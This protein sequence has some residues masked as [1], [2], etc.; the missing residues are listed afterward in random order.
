MP[1]IHF[2]DKYRNRFF[3][4]TTPGPVQPHMDSECLLW[5]AGKGKNGYGQ[6]FAGSTVYAHRYAY[7]LAHGQ[8]DPQ[9]LILHKC[10]VKLCVNPNHLYQGT[11]FDNARDRVERGGFQ[12]IPRGEAWHAVQRKQRRDTT[13]KMVRLT[14]DDVRAMRS[15]YKPGQCGGY[16]AIAERYGVSRTTAYQIVARIT[17]AHVV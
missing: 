13:R 10:D 16:A 5:T 7:L 2:T 3:S 14:D 12:N 11:A 17:W 1:V 9:R 4:H 8:L 15:E 6:F